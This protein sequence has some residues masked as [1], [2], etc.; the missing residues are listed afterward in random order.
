MTGLMVMYGELKIV[1]LRSRRWLAI[2]MVMLAAPVA[3]QQDPEWRFSVSPYLWALGVD[4]SVDTRWG[5]FDVDMST[6]DI[7][8]NLDFAFMG[9]FEARNGRWGLI[10]DT[11]HATLD[12]R[13]DTPF[14]LLFSQGRVET[15][16]K[17]L[18]G[19]VAYRV[20]ES[21]RLAVDLMGGVRVSKLAV[22]LTLSP[23]LLPGQ[24][25]GVSDSWVDPV[26]GGRARVVLGDNW[27]ATAF[28]DV[29]TFG[30]ADSTWQ[31]FASLGYQLDERWSFQGGW[32]YFSA[33]KE[34][35]GVDVETEFNGPLLGLTLR[36]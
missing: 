2:L 15:T 12:E 13:R 26:I 36:F 21:E 30:D 27:F 1:T 6:S 9:T 24:R 8:S 17:A 7:L 29:G 10:A 22:D 11:F 31:V 18:S 33:E 5:T 20:S 34:M 4:S 25:L 14:G 16:A 32:R 35:D 19:Y 28:A 3:A 23:G